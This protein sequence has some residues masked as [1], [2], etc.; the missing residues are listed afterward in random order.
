VADKDLQLLQYHEDGP[1]TIGTIH[2]STMLDGRLV[3]TFGAQALS[4][5]K[6]RNGLNFLID[7]AGVDYLSSAALTELIRIND[8]VIAGGGTMRVCGLTPQIQ[9]VFEI[10]RFDKSFDIHPG[11]NAAHAAARFKRAIAIR[12]EEEAWNKRAGQ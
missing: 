6:P 9:K 8:A 12:K 11:E 10:T 2:N 5:V 1:I 4:Y 3:E 7:F